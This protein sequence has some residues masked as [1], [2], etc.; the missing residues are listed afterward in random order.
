MANRE[1]D[2]KTVAVDTLD[3]IGIMLQRDVQGP[4]NKL[5]QADWGTML[6]RWIDG[7][8]Q[9][10]ETTVNQGGQ[11]YNVVC[12]VHTRDVTND[13]GA[14]VKTAPSIAG[15]FRDMVEGFFDWVLLCEAEVK[16][17]K[18][19]TETVYDSNY[20]VRTIP[21][22]KFHTCKGGGLPPIVS[23]THSALM[24]VESKEF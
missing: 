10:T 20:F 6:N 23:G 17:R 1:F 16:A 9:L 13:S 24:E 3:M 11:Y 22:N 2:C 7:I 5:T 15:G 8:G 12:T 18:E 19:G 21:P 14:L 4:R